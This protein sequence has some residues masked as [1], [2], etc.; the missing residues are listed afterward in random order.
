MA[1]VEL[2]LVIGTK[3]Q[4]SGP[5]PPLPVRARL[6]DVGRPAVQLHSQQRL[7]FDGLTL[8]PELV[9]PRCRG[10]EGSLL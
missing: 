1:P 3:Q 2:K 6:P 5:E 7:E 4:L 8:G 9:G 10:I